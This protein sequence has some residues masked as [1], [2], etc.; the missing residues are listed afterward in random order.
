MPERGLRGVIHYLREQTGRGPGGGIPDAE[1][2]RRWVSARDEAAFELLLWRHA[3]MVMGVC[4]RLLRDATEAEDAAQA[5]FLALACRAGSISRRTAPAGWLYRVAYRAA[6][7]ARAAAER[8]P[9]PAPEA[10]EAVAAPPDDELLWRDLRPVLDDEIRRLPEKYRL[11]FVLCQLEGRTNEEAARELGCPLGTVLSRLARAREQLRHR[12][13]RRGLALPGAAVAAAWAGGDLSA[14]VPAR[15]AGQVLR[16]ALSVAA[17]RGNSGGVAPAVWALVQDL[18]R[19]MVMVKL[20]ASVVLLLAVG[21]LGTGAG[22]LARHWGA[23]PQAPPAPVEQNAA[24]AAA[25]AG[26]HP[27][28]PAPG[29]AAGGQPA[30][31]PAATRAPSHLENVITL[32]RAAREHLWEEE[33]RYRVQEEHWTDEITEARRQLIRAEERLRAVEREQAAQRHR[34]RA[35]I[36]AVEGMLPPVAPAGKKGEP[37][38][39]PP[40]LRDL[41]QWSRKREEQ[42]IA[43]LVEAREELAR[44]E[45]RLRRIE[46]EQA[47]QREYALAR[48]RTAAEDALRADQ[49]DFRPLPAAAGSGEMGRRLETLTREVQELRRA[50]ERLRPGRER[51]EGP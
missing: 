16:M 20:K 24:P 11:P 22:A 12:L 40:A 13:T 17:G 48:V 37:E 1:L 9:A 5:T 38:P 30:G 43:A 18:V 28:T 3:P 42:R 31:R 47:I 7:R 14:A 50:V 26:L 32:Q 6:L 8:R 15:F 49:G 4:R 10:L 35:S 45:E 36:E 44:W 29:K 25:Q 33:Q 39:D 23:G 51:P 21:L 27:A 2:L 46:R 41:Q 34:E 19:E